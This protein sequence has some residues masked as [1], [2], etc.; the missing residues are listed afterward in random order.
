M[1]NKILVRHVTEVDPVDCPC[2]KSMRILT[3]KDNPAIS[4]HYTETKDAKSHYHK[5]TTE[6]YYILEGNGKMLLGVDLI[7]LKPGLC[8]HIPSG[9]HHRVLGNIKTLVIAL[10]AFDPDDEFFD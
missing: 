6:I 9:I 7:E 8:I 4:L 5:K 10:P 1:S 3:K 2:G